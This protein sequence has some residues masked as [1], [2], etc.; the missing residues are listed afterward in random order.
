MRGS[1]NITLAAAALI[2]SAIGLSACHKSGGADESNVVEMNAMDGSMN[3]MTVV[4]SATLDAGG[5][6]NTAGENMATDNG[7]NAT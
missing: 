7:S 1:F 3:D 5:S 4:D 2:A 6:A